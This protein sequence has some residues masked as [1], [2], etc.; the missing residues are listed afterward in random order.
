MLF[1]SFIQN[2]SIAFELI[3]KRS[4]HKSKTKDD[5]PKMEQKT[6]PGGW[7]RMENNFPEPQANQQ[8]NV[9]Y[10]IFFLFL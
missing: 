5:V 8:G 1:Y 2:L 3:L 9:L 4:V 10:V 6:G 7:F